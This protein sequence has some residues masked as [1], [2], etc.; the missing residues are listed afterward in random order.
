MSLRHSLWL[1][2]ALALATALPGLADG[3]DARLSATRVAEGDQVVLTLS[4]DTATG[5]GQPDLAALDTDFTVLG[6]ASGSQTT[7]VNGVRSDRVTWQITLAP[8]HGGALTV[9][10]IAAGS[11]SSA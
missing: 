8:K 10:A 5:A 2:T 3:L 1:T 4:A 6:T 9:P 7:I 11:A